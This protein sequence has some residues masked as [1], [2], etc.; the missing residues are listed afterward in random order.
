MSSAKKQ[1]SVTVS[2]DGPY[3]VSGDA[4]L[5]EQVIVANADGKSLQW[6][7][8]VTL[9]PLR[10]NTRCVAA[11]THTERPSATA[12]QRSASTAAK[13]PHARPIRRRQPYST[14]PALALLDAKRCT[15]T[16]D[17]ATRMA[18]YGTRSRTSTIRK[19]ARCFSAKCIIALRVVSSPSTRPQEQPSRRVCPSESV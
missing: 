5:S 16:A 13:L 14:G 1:I 3:I 12:P 11:G 17:F 7:E 9:M 15:R 18:T 6:R 8:K 10:K 19:F 2:K 4:P